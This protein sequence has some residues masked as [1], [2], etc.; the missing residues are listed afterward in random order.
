MTKLYVTRAESVTSRYKSDL[1]RFLFFLQ[2][3]QIYD[4]F[5]YYFHFLFCF[6]VF[7]G[8]GSGK[9]DWTELDCSW[10]LKQLHSFV[11]PVAII[12]LVVYLSLP[13]RCV[14]ECKYLVKYVC[15]WLSRV[16]QLS[17]SVSVSDFDAD[18]FL[19]LNKD[20][21]FKLSDRGHMKSFKW[22]ATAAQSHWTR[23]MT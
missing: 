5:K 21:F 8:F 15:L 19:V 3:H 16:L 10:A 14:L 9:L 4:L 11:V 22:Q 13:P 1:C 23:Y 12:V 17:V 6:F 18:S 2:E 20:K 7:A